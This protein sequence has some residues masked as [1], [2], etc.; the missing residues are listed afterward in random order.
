MSPRR[1]RLRLEGAAA[2]CDHD[3][4]GVLLRDAAALPSLLEADGSG[5]LASLARHRVP[6]LIAMG[7]TRA[8]AESLAAAFELGRRVRAP[9]R[10]NVALDAPGAAFAFV[11]PMLVDEEREVVLAVVLDIR[12]R[13]TH[14]A[15]V[16]QGGVDHCAIDPREVFVPAL[17]ERGSAVL[18]A[19]NHPSGDCTPSREDLELTRRLMA[20]GALLGLPLLDHLI[21]ASGAPVDGAQ[22]FVSLASLGV[23]AT[24]KRGAGR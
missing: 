19:H 2:L 15:R 10:A 18:L 4:I 12:N 9:P 14:V 23:I 6:E 5:L 22:P 3:L 1:Q 17:R 13:P 7:L 16:A 8:D 20:A 21:V 11:A 24:P